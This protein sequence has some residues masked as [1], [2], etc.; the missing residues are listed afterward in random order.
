MK[1]RHFVEY[2][3]NACVTTRAGRELGIIPAGTT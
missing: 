1:T 3:M 2:R